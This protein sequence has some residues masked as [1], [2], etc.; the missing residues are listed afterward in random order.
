MRLEH[1]L[2]GASHAFDGMWIVFQVS[3]PNRISF[4]FLIRFVCYISIM[5]VAA[6]WSGYDALL[7]SPIAQLVRAP[8]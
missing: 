6:M 2:S 5:P 4:F 7:N 3:V 8:H 1:L